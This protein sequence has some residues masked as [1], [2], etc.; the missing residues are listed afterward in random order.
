MFTGRNTWST[1]Y[2]RGALYFADLDAKLKT[3]QAGRVVD[4]IRIMISRI[5]D[6]APTTAATWQAVLRENAGPWAL[7]DWGEMMHGALIRPAPGAF[8]RCLVAKSITTGW[9]DLGF[10]GST[11]L[12][13]GTVITGLNPKSN[14]ARAGLR[15]GDVLSVG[16]DL[17]QYTDRLARPMTL[18]VK[19]NSIAQ[20]VTFDPHEGQGEAIQWHYDLGCS[21]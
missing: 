18:L 7:T 3:R 15:N 13:P 21:S 6:G 14:A 19:R 10:T 5:H 1:L 16:I 11:H 9:F 4:L 12:V 20:S 8:G 2:R 17:N